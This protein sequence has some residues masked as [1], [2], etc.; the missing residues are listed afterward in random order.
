LRSW[1]PKFVNRVRTE[2]ITKV[3]TNKET[4]KNK[5]TKT[6]IRIAFYGKEVLWDDPEQDGCARY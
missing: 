3:R 1:N 2:I 4:G 5:D 6:G